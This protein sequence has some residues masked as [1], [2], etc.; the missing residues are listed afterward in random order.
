MC[1]I[2]PLFRQKR[3]EG[4]SSSFRECKPAEWRGDVERKALLLIKD[5]V[6][7][8]PWGRQ[9]SGGRENFFLLWR[10]TIP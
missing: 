3:G 5:S 8:G 2:L 1:A 10:H 9:L 6:Y 7:R 4:E